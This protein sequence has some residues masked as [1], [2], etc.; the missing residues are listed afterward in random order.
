[1]RND[2]KL[3]LIKMNPSLKIPPFMTIVII[4]LYF[5]FNISIKIILRNNILAILE[6]HS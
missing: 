2:S 4:I 5:I 1:M 6:L 3:M